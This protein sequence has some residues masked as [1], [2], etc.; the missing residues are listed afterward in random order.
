[1]AGK[2]RAKALRG[3]V[4]ASN[5]QPYRKH[6]ETKHFW[7]L[8]A[9]IVIFVGG[10]FLCDSLA[11]R[12][13]PGPLT[14]ALETIVVDAFVPLKLEQILL[15]GAGRMGFLAMLLLLTMVSIGIVVMFMCNALRSFD[16]TSLIH[17]AYASAGCVLF[18]VFF[19]LLG[20]A[21]PLRDTGSLVDQAIFDTGRRLSEI[22]GGPK[23]WFETVK[24]IIKG[25]TAPVALA[26]TAIA[27][28]FVGSLIANPEAP[29]EDEIAA[30][31][32]EAD[33]YLYLGAL[34]L[35]IGILFEYTWTRW[36]GFFL[37]SVPS[38][39]G[40][41]SIKDAYIALA[42]SWNTY[43]GIHYSI[44]LA[45]IYVPVA[46]ILADRTN[47]LVRAQRVTNANFDQEKYLKSKGLDLSF[48]DS[49]RA[50]VAICAPFLAG[51]ISG[52][53]GYLIK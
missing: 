13:V 53:P 2:A 52:L 43:K 15:E 31:R 5:A 25:L 12:F 49:L 34:L 50:V 7:L 21:G 10:E 33:G 47:R 45:S 37:P 26:A 3:G 19:F 38:A 11:S 8:V 46:L 23:D 4:N 6:I 18:A 40:T 27:L 24:H 42:G 44:F 39:P 20:Q 29:V 35:V 22:A 36:L 32:K 16:R 28:G 14:P 1:M 17:M 41:P 51:A 48:A 30:Q 9:P